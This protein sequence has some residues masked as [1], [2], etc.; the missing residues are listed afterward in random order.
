MSNSSN[1]LQSFKDTHYLY[2]ILYSKDLSPK[3]NNL[4]VPL[5]NKIVKDLKDKVLYSST[6]SFIRAV[7]Y[8][9]LLS[10]HTNETLFT[11]LQAV[12]DIL[13]LPSYEA[14]SQFYIDLYTMLKK[15]DIQFSSLKELKED[16]DYG[17]ILEDFDN[18]IKSTY[19]KLGIK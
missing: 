2:N 4:N 8:T 10:M 18:C 9:S 17:G 6:A 7:I 5:V 12:I 3:N 13:K 11:S 15:E 16:K 1:I 19:S 14:N